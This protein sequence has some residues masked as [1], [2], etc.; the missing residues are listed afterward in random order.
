MSKIHHFHK[1]SNLD[2]QRAEMWKIE[3]GIVRASTWLED[4]SSTT[5]GFWG[6]GDIVG[7]GIFQ[8]EDDRLE[9]LTTVTASPLLVEN[10]ADGVMLAYIKQLQELLLIRSCKRIE[11]M[12]LKLLIWLGK[13]FGERGEAGLILTAWLTHQ[14]L[15]DALS[16]S[17]VTIT[18]SM[19]QLERQGAIH[20]LGKHRLFIG[21]STFALDTMPQILFEDFAPSIRHNSII[22]MIGIVAPMSNRPLTTSR[23]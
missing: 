11:D 4:A 19:S 23:R 6:A 5:L 9:C 1:R 13:R 20:H 10:C 14:D 21:R 22:P 7:N 12:L 2:L 16:T 15:A 18:R 3:S 17:R 8:R